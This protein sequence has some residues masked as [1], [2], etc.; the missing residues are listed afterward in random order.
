MKVKLYEYI[1]VHD[2]LH[3]H[4]YF[5]SQRLKYLRLA[6][7]L[8]FFNC[9]KEFSYNSG[10]CIVY[11]NLAS[12]F[13]NNAQTR[14]FDQLKKEYL[15]EIKEEHKTYYRD[16]A[17]KICSSQTRLKFSSKRISD[18]WRNSITET[19]FM[20][21][22]LLNAKGYSFEKVNCDRLFIYGKK[23]T[24]KSLINYANI[25]SYENFKNVYSELKSPAKFYDY[26]KSL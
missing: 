10:C 12:K 19:C 17:N 20:T 6:Y 2:F 1:D 16:V 14:K 26:L 11:G 9:I 7:K 21:F 15:D 5:L 25:G 23:S 8:K 18:I 4:Q 3:E 22:Y 13:Y 24:I